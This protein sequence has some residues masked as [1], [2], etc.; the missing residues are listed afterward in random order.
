[1]LELFDEYTY[2]LTPYEK[3]TLLPLFLIGFK[4]KFGSASAVTNKMIVSKLRPK[5]RITDARVRK[6]ISY[7]RIRGLL[8]GLMASSRGYYIS[9]DPAEIESYIRS[10]N[11]RIEAIVAIRI[12]MQDYLLTITTL[13][14]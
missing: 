4:T 2:D 6:I 11:G 5:Y 12:K 3:E 9:D 10:L 1:M 14:K 8:P 13:K 7:I